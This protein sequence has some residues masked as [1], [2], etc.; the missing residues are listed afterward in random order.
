MRMTSAGLGRAAGSAPRAST[1]A[2]P[3]VTSRETITVVTRAA[4][5]PAGMT[6]AGAASATAK[7][8]SPAFANSTPMRRPPLQLH[9]ERR[10]ST[11]TATHLTTTAVPSR[12]PNSRASSATTAGSTRS[13][14][15]TKK[16][17]ANTLFK[18]R[19]SAR[20]CSA[21]PDSLMTR[22]ARKAPRATDNPSSSE[23]AAISPMPATTVMRKSSRST[24]WTTNRSP[25]CTSRGQERQGD[26]ERDDRR[27]DAGEGGREDRRVGLGREARPR[28]DEHHRHDVLQD[29][30]R[31]DRRGD[32]L[33]PL[34]EAAEQR[35]QRS[36]GGHARRPG[37]EQAPLGRKPER[38][39]EG[40]GHRP[41]DQ[42]LTR[43]DDEAGPQR[44]PELAQGEFDPDGE[45]QK[46][47]AELGH[48]LRLV[49]VVDE[50]EPRR[51]H[52][53]PRQ[54]VA[55]HLGDAHQA[56]GDGPARSRYHEEEEEFG[57]FRHH[58][59]S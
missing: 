44:R 6:S 36:G 54:Q 3:L 1:A 24:C 5:G 53:R 12:R 17:A 45:E 32:P 13:P 55:R 23:A 50:T 46:G 42:Q 16:A 28:P 37:Q 39:G 22:P 25:Q 10:A 59:P 34:A 35:Q 57:G 19:V 11:E 40:E 27:E 48:E 38:M 52:E 47:Q 49:R 8:N 41:D 15:E 26:A 33:A 56:G 30:D 31:H 43:S 29:R 4:R 51:A 2:T 14:A 58:R 18:A 9:P 7:E 21:Y 20:A